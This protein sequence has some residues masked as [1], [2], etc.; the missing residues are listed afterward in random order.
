[1]AGDLSFGDTLLVAAIGGVA[2][3]ASNHLVTWRLATKTHQRDARYLAQRLVAILERFSI[4]CAELISE[5]D[6]YW[7]S[8][9]ALGR[10]QPNL[11]V[12]SEFPADADWKALD[13]AL[14]ERVFAFPNEL[15]LADR[16][17][18]F[19]YEV[20]G[21]PHEASTE[22]SRQAGKFGYRAWD[23]AIA[24]RAKNTLPASGLV[25]ITWDFVGTLKAKHDQ[26]RNEDAT[27]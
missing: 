1:M 4:D 10:V 25:D 23:I 6:L 19:A 13:A 11:P 3:A 20:N 16:M 21:E 5:N 8:K 2:V 26:V 17:V 9:G 12:L 24:L 14:A 7:Q 18:S 27:I 22:A 15:A